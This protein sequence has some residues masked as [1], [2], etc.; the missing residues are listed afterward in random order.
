VSN[1]Q[2]TDVYRLSRLTSGMPS[3][4]QSGKKYTHA[5]FLSLCSATSD[6][7]GTNLIKNNTST[8][9][10]DNSD[11]I[12]MGNFNNNSAQNSSVKFDLL[13]PNNNDLSFTNSFQQQ[14]QQQQQHISKVNITLSGQRRQISMVS[15]LYRNNSIINSNDNSNPN[16]NNNNINLQKDETSEMIRQINPISSMKRHMFV[17][18]KKMTQTIESPAFVTP[19]FHNR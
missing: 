19:P 17:N 14:Q 10:W 8:N 13:S 16:L 4:R 1:K 9:S 3:S 5:N 18:S 12:E 7:N 2:L 6:T 11:S 15:P